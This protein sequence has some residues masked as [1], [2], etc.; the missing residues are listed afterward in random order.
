MGC[1]IKLV[2]YPSQVAMF[3]AAGH[4][5]DRDFVVY[6]C[7]ECFE[8]MDRRKCGSSRMAKKSKPKPKPRPA[9]RPSG[10]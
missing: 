7:L 10:Y 5:R 8:A 3:E 6:K 4:V 9:P 1:L 2:I